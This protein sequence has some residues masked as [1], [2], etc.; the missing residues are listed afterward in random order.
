MLP[1]IPS[2]RA[3]AP[4]LVPVALLLSTSVPAVGQARDA[5]I[6]A[7]GSLW[8]EVEPSLVNWSEQYAL[9]SSNPDILDG[10]REPLYKHFDGAIADRLFPGPL[11]FIEALNED[12]GA[13]GFDPI[14]PGN[15]SLGELDFSDVTSQI[16]RLD[17][18]F[19]LGLLDRFAV[20]ARAPFVLTDTD[21]AFAFDSAAATVTSATVAFAGSTFLED[22]QGAITQLGALVADGS[23]MGPEL[24]QAMA[25]LED[26]DA[27]LTALETRVAQGSFVPTA[28]SLAGMQMTGRVDAFASSFDAFGIT[29]P[30]LALP[31]T[32]SAVTLP[33]IFE[34]AP[35]SAALPGSSRQGLLLGDAEVSLRVGLIDQITRREPAPGTRPAVPDS[36]ARA[37]AAERPAAVADSTPGDSARAARGDPAAAD[38]AAAGAEGQAMAAGAD[39]GGIRLRTTV[40]GLLRIPTGSPG[41]PPFGDPADFFDVPIGDGQMDVEVSLYQDIQLDGWVLIRSV[42]RYGIQMADELPLRIHAPDR[43]YAFESTQAVVRRDLG[44]YLELTVRPAL[45]LGSAIWVGLEYGYWR[46]QATSFSLPQPLP[47][48]ADASSLERE[49]AQERHM[50]GLG[51]AYDLSEARSRDELVTGAV[52]VRPPWRFEVSMRRSMSG[53]GGRTP[54]ALRFL[55]TFRVPIEAF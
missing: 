2:L 4:W 54:A 30:A 3:P 43:P 45:R 22:M 23:L 24:A 27:F 21:V 18:G 11:P 20:G 16:R 51:F 8:L 55:A 52:P 15:F 48:V 31:A 5:R 46:L 14:E 40:G 34:N 35:V 53:S 42:A 39:R 37:R 38:S 10:Q 19:E 6:P 1:R 12:A 28:P 13:L 29:L 7:H 50:L 17:L 41:F 44:D 25:L 26:A 33:G 47:D 36:V 9:D 32:G 49:T